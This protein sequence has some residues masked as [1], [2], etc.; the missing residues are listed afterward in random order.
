MKGCGRR[1]TVNPKPLTRPQSTPTAGPTRIAT[2][3]GQPA[4]S[5]IARSIVARAM[6]EPTERS[7]PAVRMTT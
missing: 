5:A 6:I 4:T 2:G 3:H 1:S 7:I